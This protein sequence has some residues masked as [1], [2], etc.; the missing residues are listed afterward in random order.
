MNIRLNLAKIYVPFWI[1][2]KKLR[3][4]FALTAQA[5][6]SEEPTLQGLSRKEFLEKYAFFTKENAEKL[7][8]SKEK[9]KILQ[10][11]LYQ[12]AFQMGCD[13]R[14][15]L[16]ISSSE[17]FMAAARIL[18]HLIGIDFHGKKTGQITIH[19]C[20]FSQFYS[21]DIC[22]IISSLDRG[23]LAG[24]SGGMGKLEFLDRL[25][26]GAECCR[27]VFHFGDGTV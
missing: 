11:Q 2:K 15:E 3:E 20:Y 21:E 25:T 10:D 18:Y 14:K 9:T 24:L 5:F 23:I 1:Q 12:K 19:K 16:R 6:Q 17:E 4:L 7:L 27:A 8:D 26:S 13:L 22:K